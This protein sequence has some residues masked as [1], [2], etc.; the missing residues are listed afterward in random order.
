MTMVASKKTNATLPVVLTV[1]VLGMYNGYVILI[2]KNVLLKFRELND[3]CHV[4]KQAFTLQECYSG[5]KG[6]R[7]PPFSMKVMVG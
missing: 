7:Y 5:Q 4:K 1:M 2:F 3:D 6:G